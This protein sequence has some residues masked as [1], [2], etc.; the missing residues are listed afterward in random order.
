M[1]KPWITTDILNKCKERDKLLKDIMEEN[2]PNRIKDLREKYTKMRN[3]ITSEKRQS[4]KSFHVSQFNHNSTKASKIWQNIRKIVNVK[5]TK[6]TSIKLL[7]DDEI[8]SDPLKN[9]NTFN[10]HFSKL[11]A[12]VQE[13]IPA[14]RGSYKDYLLKK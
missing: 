6:N 8:I 9:A 1:L 11:G 4:K 2:D 13:K 14:E 5:S 12:K 7:I 3:E 10:S